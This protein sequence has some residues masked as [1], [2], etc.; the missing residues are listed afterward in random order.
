[1]PSFRLNMNAIK[2]FQQFSHGTRFGLLF[3]NKVKKISFKLQTS[4]GF[5]ILV[6]IDF[7]RENP[8]R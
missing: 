1:M 8:L 7:H 2:V 6:D 3:A 4:N 5:G